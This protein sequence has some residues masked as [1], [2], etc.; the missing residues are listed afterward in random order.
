MSLDFKIVQVSE[1]PEILDYEQRKLAEQILNEEDR[2]LLSWNAR[3]RKEALEHYIPMGWSFLARDTAVKS[4]FS[5]DGL[6]MG[7][8]IAQP[9]LFL[10]GQTQSLWVEHLQYSSLQVRDEISDLA[11]RLSREKHLQKVY[12]PKSPATLNSTKHMRAEEW[13]PQVLSAKTTK[14]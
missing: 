1:I 14:A 8:F 3:W 6:L 11:Y 9:L 5:D 12:F 2:A 4:E 7:Y 13:N 10:D